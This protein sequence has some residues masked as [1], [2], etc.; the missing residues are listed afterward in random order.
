M[1][2]QKNTSWMTSTSFPV[3]SVFERIILTV[4]GE[5]ERKRGEI[6]VY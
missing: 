5:R 3:R 1:S 2:K 6:A 4:V